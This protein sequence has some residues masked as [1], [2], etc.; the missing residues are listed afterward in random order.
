MKIIES[1]TEIRPWPGGCAVTIGKY[2]GMHLG[3]QRILTALQDEAARLRLPSVV[4]LSEPQPEEFF[5]GADAPPRLSHFD[6]KVA[7]L[8]DAGV[9]AVVRLRFDRARSE[10]QAESFVRQ[11]LVD[12]LMARCL[13]VGD[14]FRFGV[15]RGGDLALLRDM[16]KELGFSVRGVGACSDEGERISSTLVRQC[17]LSGDCARASRLLGRPYSISG[18]VFEGRKLGRQIGVP[19][20]NLAL[21]AHSL[22][23]S[24]VF[25]VRVSVTGGDC[26]G[27]ANLGY[28]PTVASEPLPSLEVHLLDYEGDLYGQRL[29]VHFLEKLR[30]ERKFPGLDALKEQICHDIAAARMIFAGSG[31]EVAAP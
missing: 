26:Y 25:A 3:H 30:N 20:A 21:Q 9:D 22:P 31:V 23:M 15:R 6:D 17:L 13:V 11:F 14:D 10:Q 28:K 5:S 16:G 2:D 8:H 18:L 7:F 1:S 12:E 4:V 29:R 19:T 24:G 27:V